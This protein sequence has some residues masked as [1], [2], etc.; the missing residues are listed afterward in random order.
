V[1]SEVVSSE[2]VSSEAVNS[3]VVS[4]EGA[5]GGIGASNGAAAASVGEMVHRESEVASGGGASGEMAGPGAGS[6]PV[7][8]EE[9]ARPEAV[10]PPPL[11]WS[12]VEARRAR[13]RFD[14]FLFIDRGG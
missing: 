13:S 4:S 14:D 6:E 7:S 2:A 3:A 12:D 9:S 8:L 10:R 1:S 11:L 5:N